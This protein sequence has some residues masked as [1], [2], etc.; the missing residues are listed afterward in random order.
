MLK[1][2]KIFKKFNPFSTNVPLLYP[3]KT[4]EDLWFSDAF[5]GYRSGTLVQKGLIAHME[6]SQRSTLLRASGKFQTFFQ[7]LE[8]F[9]TSSLWDLQN[10]LF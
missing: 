5:K 10:F 9:K 7:F 4:L 3:L 6:I 1:F 2:I 8:N